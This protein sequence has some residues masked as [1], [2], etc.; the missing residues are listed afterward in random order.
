MASCCGPARVSAP[1][2]LDLPCPRCGDHGR[3][4]N[5]VTVRSLVQ[6]GHGKDIGDSDYNLCQSAD[7]EVVYY[8]RARHYSTNEIAV[9]IA[10][11]DPEGPVTVCYCHRLSEEDIVQEM[12]TNVAARSFEEVS[13]IFGMK[14]CSC[15]RHHPFGGN[16][17]CATAVARAVKQGLRDPQVIAIDVARSKLPR[18]HVFEQT[19]GC[20]GK[21]GSEDLVEFLRRRLASRADVRSFDLSRTKSAP[22][23]PTLAQMIADGGNTCLPAF[24][25]DGAVLATGT[26]P[27]FMQAMSW[28]N[29]T[30]ASER[31]IA[32]GD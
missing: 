28:F 14:D 23:P 19:E 32:H 24:T 22:V 21:S 17:A 15:E 30:P 11:K 29:R 27:N 8:N 2:R 13:D 16:C 25:I 31:K 6:P 18:I 5:N 4:V 3:A 10:F 26:L 1:E 12:R 20:C 9:R 7:C